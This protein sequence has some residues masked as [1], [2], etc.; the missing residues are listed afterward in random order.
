[1]K[2]QLS[3]RTVS[4]LLSFCLCFL[5]FAGI[6]APVSA[7]SNGKM[8][9]VNGSNTTNLKIGFRNNTFDYPNAKFV[10]GKQYRFSC[11]YKN[12]NANIG[13]RGSMFRFWYY[14]TSDSMA[15]INATSA[16]ATESYNSSTFLY[17]LTFT[18][19]ADCRSYNKRSNAR[20]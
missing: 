8:F 9:H 6:H 2:S 17:T 15:G 1:M 11:K 3:K 20:S 14:N 18:M 13:F 5:C 19:P 4:L 7:S 10:A 16:A 12:T